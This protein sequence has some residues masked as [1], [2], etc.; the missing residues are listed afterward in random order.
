MKGTQRAARVEF[1]FAGSPLTAAFR[2]CRRAT[3]QMTTGI[4]PM[5]RNPPPYDA[6]SYPFARYKTAVTI[7]PRAIHATPT[8]M[9][10]RSHWSRFSAS[11][12][13]CQ[14]NGTVA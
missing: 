14:W 12:A 2:L 1:V 13:F 3:R 11:V 8:A 7:I 5:M 4:T 9:T 10:T 6:S